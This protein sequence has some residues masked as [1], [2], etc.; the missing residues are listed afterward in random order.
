MVA[1]TG[2]VQSASAGIITEWDHV[3]IA[4]P[5]QMIMLGLGV[6]GLAIALYRKDTAFAGALSIAVTGSITAIR[7][8]PILLLLA[9]P[10]LAAFASHPVVR[11][12][13]YSR[14]IMLANGAVAIVVA[15]AAVTFPNLAHVGRPDPG[16][17]SSSVVNAIPSGCKLF[18]SYEIGGFVMLERPDVPV[19]LDS[20]NDLYGSERVLKDKQIIDGKGDLEQGLEGAGCVLVPPTSGLA[21]Y[22]QHNQAWRRTAGDGAAVLF[23]RS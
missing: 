18:N 11:R 10:V 12:Y 17:Y 23:V 19:S 2:Q 13:T 3:N 15:A 4:D 20:R 16:R 14:R 7:I 21:Q 8:L 6:A 1:Q 22:L 9:V 5:I